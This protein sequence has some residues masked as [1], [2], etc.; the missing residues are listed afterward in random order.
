MPH[1]RRH[2]ARGAEQIHRSQ[3]ERAE[4]MRERLLDATIDCLVR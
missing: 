3:A 1:P 2:P 4:Q